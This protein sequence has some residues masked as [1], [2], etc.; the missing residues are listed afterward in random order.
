MS[1]HEELKRGKKKQANSVTF[2]EP[3]RQQKPP[4]IGALRR[5]TFGFKKSLRPICHSPLFAALSLLI[6]S[7]VQ[8]LSAGLG[9]AAPQDGWAGKRN[10]MG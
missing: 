9:M 3:Q 5:R 2:F 7:E 4:S 8:N 1:H 10:G 6:F